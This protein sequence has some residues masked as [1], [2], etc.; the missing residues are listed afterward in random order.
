MPFGAFAGVHAVQHAAQQ[1]VVVLVAIGLE[2][3]ILRHFGE[4]LV[5]DMFDIFLHELIVFAPCDPGRA[6]RRLLGAGRD[7]MGVEVMQAKLIDQRLLDL[8]M[9]DEKAI[10]VDLAA[11][12]IEE[13][14]HMTVDIDRLAVDA[15]AGEIGNIV[16]CGRVS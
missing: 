7:L 9:Q 2:I 6:H 3:E 8:L 13:F 5:A 16:A 1:I 14:R 15:V 10:G 11:A 12:E 4:P